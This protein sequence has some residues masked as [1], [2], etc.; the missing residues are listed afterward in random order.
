MEAGY[1]RRRLAVETA[2]TQN[3]ARL[4]GLGSR[5]SSKQRPN[6]CCCTL[7]VF[8]DELAQAG[9]VG[10]EPTRDVD[11]RANGALVTVDVLQ[12]SAG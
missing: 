9:R 5:C 2:A 6:N 8:A 1:V 11:C 3:Q 12:V 10:R 4:R 7:G